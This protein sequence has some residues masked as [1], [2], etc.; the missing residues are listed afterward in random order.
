MK[1][2]PLIILIGFTSSMAFAQSTEDENDNDIKALEKLKQSK[3]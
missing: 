1:A 2:A 3:F